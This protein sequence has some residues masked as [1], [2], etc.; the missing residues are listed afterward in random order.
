MNSIFSELLKKENQTQQN[1]AFQNS[2]NQLL[3]NSQSSNQVRNEFSYD[4]IFH[5]TPYKIL[6]NEHRF[7]SIFKG[8]FE[9]YYGRNKHFQLFQHLRQKF[10]FT[11]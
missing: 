2:F 7:F 11:H 1:G 9:R 10:P 4:F 3:H 6:K 5:K 8:Y